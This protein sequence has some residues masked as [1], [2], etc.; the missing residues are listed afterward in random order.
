ML[1]KEI[2]RHKFKELFETPIAVI[3]TDFVTICYRFFISDKFGLG[4]SVHYRFENNESQIE[5][6][7]L[8]IEPGI[9]CDL[10]SAYVYIIDPEKKAPFINSTVINIYNQEFDNIIKG[11]REQE[12]D[13]DVDQEVDH[14]D[15][16]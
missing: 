11:L 16:I 3:E 13:T 15:I 6:Y 7:M 8:S 2:S 10:V 9:L 4:M 14:G 1:L 12:Y 5:Y